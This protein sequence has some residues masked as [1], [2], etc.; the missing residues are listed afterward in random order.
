MT[1]DW[2]PAAIHPVDD[3]EVFTLSEVVEEYYDHQIGDYIMQTDCYSVEDDAFLHADDYR[4]RIV[5]WREIEFPAPPEIY[6]DKTTAIIHTY[7]SV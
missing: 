4:L 5:C 7:S 1:P 3:C 2:I 6:L